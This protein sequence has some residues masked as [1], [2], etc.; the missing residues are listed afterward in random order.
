MGIKENNTPGLKTVQCPICRTNVLETVRLHNFSPIALSFRVV[1]RASIPTNVI[2]G[3][4]DKN[5]SGLREEKY[6]LG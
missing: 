4:I 3:G 2:L 6:A 1:C 5:I